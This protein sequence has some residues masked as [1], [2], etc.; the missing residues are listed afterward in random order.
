HKPEVQD[1]VFHLL[2]MEEQEIRD[3][4][5]IL[6]DALRF[7]APPHGGIAFGLDR[8]VMLMAGADSIR[9]VMVFPKTQTAA[10]PLTGAPAE[11][12]DPQL[13][14]LGIR[15]RKPVAEAKSE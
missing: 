1:A 9:E 13:R 8:L 7:G 15:L 4:F 14:E 2:G 6:I 3:K 12:G 10:C 5:G 11:V